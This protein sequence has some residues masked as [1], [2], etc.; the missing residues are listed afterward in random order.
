M[1]DF[2]AGLRSIHSWIIEHYQCFQHAGQVPHLIQSQEAGAMLR[3]GAGFR[4]QR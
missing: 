4:R 2:I 1:A 3:P